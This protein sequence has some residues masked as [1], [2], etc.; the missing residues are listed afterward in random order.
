MEEDGRDSASNDDQAA[1][2]VRT[3]LI[4]DVRGYTRFTQDH[5]DEEAG[6]LA[7]EFARLAREVVVASGGEVIEFRG[8]EALCVFSSARRA[9]R[10]AIELQRA[11]RRQSEGGSLFPLPIGVGLDA[12]EAVPI[13]GGY[14]GAAL[15]TAARLCSL[16]QPGQIL[17]TE[18]T[19]ALSQKVEGIR[20]RERRAVRLKGLE[21]PVR[22]L[23][24]ESVEPLPRLPL[25][26]AQ[27]G[28]RSKQT[29]IA[30]GIVAVIVA[31][32]VLSTVVRSG[33][34]DSEQR[35]DP[36]AVGAIDSGGVRSQLRLGGA[37]S[38]LAAAKDAVWIASNKAR[39]VSRFDP[40]T[41]GLETLPAGGAPAGLAVGAGSL[42]VANGDAQALLQINPRTLALIQTIPLGT[43]LRASPSGRTRSGSRTRSTA[44]CHGS[45]S[46]EA[47]SPTRSRPA[48]HRPPSPW[49]SVVSGSRT[50]RTGP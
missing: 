14:R 43:G 9:I 50:T 28:R 48:P 30:A 12:G 18:T 15:N 1:A 16:A 42:W 6:R 44:P 27:P 38:A 5:G 47:R 13:E 19:V 21:K 31:A 22:L 4:A 39:T 2:H 35:L 32:A 24:V 11:F 49:A 36:N 41:N 33:G 8:D 34:G 37:P 46:H 26:A 10:A 17:A 25:V 45:I 23:E 3:F 40:V 20:F 7:A 29:W